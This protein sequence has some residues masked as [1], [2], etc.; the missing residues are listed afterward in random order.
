MP[1]ELGLPLDAHAHSASG[2]A[3]HPDYWCSRGSGLD[4]G[5]AWISDLRTS[6]CSMQG[7]VAQPMRRGSSAVS[8]L[9]GPD[10]DEADLAAPCELCRSRPLSELAVKENHILATGGV[11]AAPARWRHFFPSRAAMSCSFVEDEPKDFVHAS[12]TLANVS[13]FVADITSQTGWDY[14]SQLLLSPQ[15]VK[16]H[17]KEYSELNRQASATL[18]DLERAKSLLKNAIAK[19][20]SQLKEEEAEQPSEE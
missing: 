18:G 6:I 4:P 10:R 16:V 7:L 11:A 15:I 1:V 8:F 13:K 20:P 14:T 2:W 5:Q 3:E 9:A 19:T 17:Q 12:Q